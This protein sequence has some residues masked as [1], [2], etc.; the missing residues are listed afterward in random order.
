MIPVINYVRSEMPVYKTYIHI[1]K[2][3]SSTKKHYGVTQSS[4]EN[5]NLSFSGFFIVT[6]GCFSFF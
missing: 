4:F 2:Q 1:F 6:G 3:P 5:F